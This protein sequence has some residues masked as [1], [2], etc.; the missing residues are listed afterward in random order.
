MKAWFQRFMSGRYGSDQ[1]SNFLCIVSLVCLILGM[2]VSG[3]LYYVGLALLIWCYFRMFSRNVS[4][5]YAENMKYLELKGRVTAWFT[6]RKVRFAQRKAYRYFRCPCCHQEI[7]IP[8]GHG[9]VSI[10][11]PKCK[12]QFIK[13]S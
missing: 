2:F 10:T 8:R 1:L 7:R 9:R 4:K 13:K 3:F 6:Q 12:T 11:C 5:R